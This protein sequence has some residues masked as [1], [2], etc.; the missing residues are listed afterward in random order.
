MARDKTDNTPC[1]GCAKKLGNNYSIQCSVCG[2]WSHKTCGEVTDEF[3]AA[4]EKQ[5]KTSGYGY[6]ACRPCSAY[7]Q[8]M[9]HRLKQLET[10]I[11][12]VKKVATDNTVNIKNLEAKVDKLASE[13][14]RGGITREDFE[15]YR[16]EERMEAQERKSRELNIVVHGVGELEDTGASTDDKWEWD[17]ASCAN[18]FKALSPRLNRDSIKF[19]RRVGP[20]KGGPRPL[21]VGFYSIRDKYL[22]LSVDTT[23]T[24]Y[25]GVSFGPDLTK[26]QREEE[27][28]MWRD[29][30]KMN[31]ELSDD[32]LSKN[33]RWRLVGRKGER[34]MIKSVVRDDQ[35]PGAASGPG[36][37]F[38]G[39]V[40]GMRGGAG[41]ARG[42]V[43]GGVY[44]QT[45][46]P[47]VGTTQRR[48]PQLAATTPAASL[49]WRPPLELE[50][51]ATPSAANTTKETATE[52]PMEEVGTARTTR[53]HSK[54]QRPNVDSDEDE[55]EPPVSQLRQ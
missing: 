53:L 35:T 45:S 41:R 32:D 25:R 23:N 55:L 9:N 47:P 33:L 52:V 36:A 17:V 22:L 5:I 1:L 6:W 28:E 2:L 18:I 24:A 42:Y 21:I 34:R 51:L 26:R 50:P 46:Q 8:G 40:R 4:I 14:T 31:S 13:A 48:A 44:Q 54:R 30:E 37:T 29:V 20:K 3:Y 7:A 49:G 10:V 15:A 38:R 39:G 27:A 11:G 19:C 16:K 43:R 12:E